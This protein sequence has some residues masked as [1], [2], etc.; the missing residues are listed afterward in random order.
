MHFAVKYGKL[1]TSL[2]QTFLFA[3]PDFVFGTLTAWC[4]DGISMSRRY[5]VQ[6]TCMHKKTPCSCFAQCKVP[7]YGWLRMACLFNDNSCPSM[8]VFFCAILDA[9][10]MV[11]QPCGDRSRLSVLA[12]HKTLSSVKVVDIGNG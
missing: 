7:G 1:Y 5:A 9:A 2:F 6:C 12:E 8:L 10:Q 11:I 3:F 4:V